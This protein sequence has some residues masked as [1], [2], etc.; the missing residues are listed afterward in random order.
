MSC[1]QKLPTPLRH[2]I[3]GWNLPPQV[4][5]TL[6]EAIGR[7]LSTTQAIGTTSVRTFDVCAGD[8]TAVCEF[9]VRYTTRE[10]DGQ[11]VLLDIDV[12]YM[13]YG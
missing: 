11:T 13:K 3:A 1:D 7:H 4:R 6:L 5:L 12:E 9:F 10:D 8:G 2:K